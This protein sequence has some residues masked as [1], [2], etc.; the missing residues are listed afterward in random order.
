MLAMRLLLL[1]SMCVTNSLSQ[2]ADQK[3]TDESKPHAESI[4]DHTD[5]G[6]RETLVSLQ[7]MYNHADNNKL[8]IFIAAAVGTV[9]LMGVIYCIYNQFYTKQ[10][11]LHAHLEEDADVSLDLRDPFSSSLSP[12]SGGR[13]E[14]A[15]DRWGYGSLS[16]TPSIIT[17]PPTLSPPPPTSPFPALSLFPPSPLRTISAQDLEKSFL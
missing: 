15:V 11:Y 3:H 10:P 5:A 8:A 2:N 14:R 7:Q 16:E 1:V 12:G 6:K 17:L 13:N 9:T 4:P